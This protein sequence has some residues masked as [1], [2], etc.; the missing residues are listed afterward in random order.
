MKKEKRG[1][2]YVWYAKKNNRIENEQFNDLELT[3]E[4]TSQINNQNKQM[5]TY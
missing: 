1:F 4:N 3:F 2:L 5:G